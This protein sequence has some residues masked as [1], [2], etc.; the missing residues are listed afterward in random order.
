MGAAWGAL[1]DDAWYARVKAEFGLDVRPVAW[2][3]RIGRHAR[4]GHSARA[5]APMSHF[6][7]ERCVQLDVLPKGQFAV[8]R[9]VSAP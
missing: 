7:C 9:S 4:S 5:F 1:D 8:L 3:R 6:E 2:P